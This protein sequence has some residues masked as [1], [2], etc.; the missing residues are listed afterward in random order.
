MELIE[1]MKSTHTCRYYRPDPVPDNVL[2][3]AIDVARFG[4]SGG[5]RQPLRWIIVRDPET[6][7]RL[8]DLYLPHWKTDLAQYL[9]GSLTA[10]ASELSRAIA[11][12]DDFAEHLH[13]APVMLVACVLTSEL[14]PQCLRDGHLNMIAGASVY[15]L[16]QN[17]CL[18]LR[19]QG[20]ATSLTTLICEE[21][22]A[23][24]EL[25][26]LPDGVL[27]ACHVVAG[28]PARPFPR[29][30]TRLPVEQ[31][32]FCERFGETCARI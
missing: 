23:V 27:T 17:L 22:L 5:N 20:V 12:A 15:P 14:H 8:R 4:P 16:V 10:G 29:K 9:E 19:D 31:I 28:Y 7:R 6:R 32:A 30:L 11:D 3:A 25:M 26:G 1:V 2:F 24:R 21:E 18:A 13:Q